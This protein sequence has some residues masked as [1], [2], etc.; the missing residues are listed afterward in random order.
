MTMDRVSAWGELN[1]FAV[2]AEIE[3]DERAHPDFKGEVGEGE[4]EVSSYDTLL[5]ALEC[6]HMVVSDEGN[7]TVKWRKPPREGETTMTFK[8]D[9]WPYG[10]AIRAYSS[11][12]NRKKGEQ[13][14]LGN[15]HRYMETLARVNPS[16]LI[17]L[18]KRSDV[19]LASVLGTFLISE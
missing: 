16:T 9:A 10:Y 7:L 6:G 3:L 13:D 17:N 19:M 2:A 5:E 4:S 1:R 11:T 14:S 18:T 15:L 12:T 8:P